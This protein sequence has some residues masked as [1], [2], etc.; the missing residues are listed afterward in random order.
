MSR[1]YQ[2]LGLDEDGCTLRT[3]EVDTLAEAEEDAESLCSEKEYLESGMVQ[4]QVV[5]FTDANCEIISDVRV[6]S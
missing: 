1:Y 3:I 4:V 6:Q 5:R 2:V